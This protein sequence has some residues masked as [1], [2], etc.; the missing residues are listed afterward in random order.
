[1]RVRKAAKPSPAAA[2]FQIESQESAIVRAYAKG[3][4]L[5]APSNLAGW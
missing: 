4:R 3:T 1:M 2:L 5:I